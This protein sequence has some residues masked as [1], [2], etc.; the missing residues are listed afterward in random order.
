MWHQITLPSILVRTRPVGLLKP[1]RGGTDLSSRQ[2]RLPTI[3]L[4]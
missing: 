2:G 3:A 4:V 1:R